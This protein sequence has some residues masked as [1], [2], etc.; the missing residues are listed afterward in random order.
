MWKLNAKTEINIEPEWYVTGEL[1]QTHVK[2]GL[3]TV[4]NCKWSD[5]TVDSGLKDVDEKNDIVNNR[6]AAIEPV[7]EDAMT[8]N[9]TDELCKICDGRIECAPT[10]ILLISLVH[11]LYGILG[12]EPNY[13]GKSRSMND[14]V[15]YKQKH[16]DIEDDRNEIIEEYDFI[17][18]GGGTAGCVVASRLSE[19]KNWKV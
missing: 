17:I 10:A 14:P 15:Q 2:R 9:I 5:Q 4:K 1:K 18:V 19:N 11:T 7:G 13:F 12:P 8:A 16:N 6:K 3:R